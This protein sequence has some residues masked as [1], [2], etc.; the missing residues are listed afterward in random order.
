MRTHVLTALLLLSLASGAR[1]EDGHHT[2]WIAKGLHNRDE[3]AIVC[4]HVLPDH[5]PSGWPCP[6][7]Q[8]CVCMFI[9]S[10]GGIM[11]SFRFVMIQ[12][13]PAT[14]RVTMS[15]PNAS[16]STLLVLSGPVVMCRK[17]TR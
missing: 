13:D 6:S 10:V 9:S 11:L 17:K 14:T 5:R 15:T 3:A 4:I 12:S 1:S 8:G 2:F 7:G 16:A